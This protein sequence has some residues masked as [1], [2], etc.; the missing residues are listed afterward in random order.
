MTTISFK[1]WMTLREMVGRRSFDH[2]MGKFTPLAVDKP[3]A[4]LTAWRSTLSDANNQPYD[5]PTRRRLNAEANQ[6]LMANIRRRGLSFYPVVG[7][8]EEA[9][10]QGQL[11]INKEM[12]FVVQPIGDMSEQQFLQEIKELLYNPTGETDVQKFGTGPY[13][14][15]Q[16]GAVVK[17][18]SRPQAFVVQH[19]DKIQPT[20]THDY[21]VEVDIGDS[22]LPRNPATDNVYTQMLFGP[23]APASMKDP[24]D[25]PDDVGNLGGE[26]GR[27]FRI[28]D[29]P[30]P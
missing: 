11:S 1:Q 2:T 5:E 4:T 18:P 15:T 8:G 12:S 7:A 26:P 17:L 3:V 24:Q 22:A 9:D 27:R 6:A 25:K 16:L 19:D 28:K 21:S 30:Q 20:G 13:P 14:H 10:K 29:R 23:R